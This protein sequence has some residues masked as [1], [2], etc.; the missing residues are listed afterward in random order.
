M[1]PVSLH[2]RSVFN[3]ALTW[4]SLISVNT[5]LIEI[6]CR[7]FLLP[8]IFSQVNYSQGFGLRVEGWGGFTASGF[9]PQSKDMLAKLNVDYKLAVGV[10][11]YF[12]QVST[13][14]TQSVQ[15]VSHLLPT[16]PCLHVQNFFNLN[17]NSDKNFTVFMWFLIRGLR[18]ILEILISF[19]PPPSRPP[20][21][22]KAEIQCIDAWLMYLTC[23]KDNRT[24]NIKK[25]FH[26]LIKMWYNPPVLIW[27]SEIRSE[28]FDVYI[29]H[30]TTTS[31]KFKTIILD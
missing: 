15:G 4:C 8:Q 28:S 6:W 26:D 9:V 18:R 1:L 24:S 29:K 10:K 23:S 3:P 25:C 5:I 16:S 21:A 14:L 30:V 17:K 19:H 2:R 13:E 11:G 27:R 31:A 22:V 20:A 12:P 7:Y